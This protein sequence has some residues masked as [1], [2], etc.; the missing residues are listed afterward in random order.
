MLTH[1]NGKKRQEC[2]KII[3]MHSYVFKRSYKCQKV[4]DN[5]IMRCNT[6]TW[7][8]I[9]SNIWY[10]KFKNCSL[11]SP[12][13]DHFLSKSDALYTE[14]LT[15]NNLALNSHYITHQYLCWYLGER[16][17]ENLEWSQ[18]PKEGDLFM[19]SLKCNKGEITNSFRSCVALHLK[20]LTCTNLKIKGSF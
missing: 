1:G 20:W 10:F 15:I 11:L 4:T 17:S 9:R 8:N 19:F 12:Y 14:I 13:S 6:C 5:Q 7:G 3:S 2:K 16:V 18:S